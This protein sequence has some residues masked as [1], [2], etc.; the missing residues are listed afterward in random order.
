MRRKLFLPFGTPD[1]EYNE[2]ITQDLTNGGLTNAEVTGA[3]LVQQEVAPGNSMSEATLVRVYQELDANS[4]PVK[5]GSDK[6]VRGEND[7]LTIAKTFIVKN[8]YNDQYAQNRIGVES[9][10]SSRK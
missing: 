1:E 4:E 7:R 5:V 8:P 10:Y 9:L 3:Y 2:T 6:I